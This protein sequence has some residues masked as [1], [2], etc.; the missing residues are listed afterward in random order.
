MRATVPADGGVAT[1]ATDAD[2]GRGAEVGDAGATHRLDGEA[3]VGVVAVVLGADV[4]A[5]GAGVVGIERVVVVV[6]VVVRGVSGA[7]RV[8]GVLVRALVV[9]RAGLG[10]ARGAG[11]E[12]ASSRSD[13]SSSDDVVVDPLDVGRVISPADAHPG[14]RSSVNS[15][16]RRRGDISPPV[17]PCGTRGPTGY[18]TAMRRFVLVAVAGAGCAPGDV[19]WGTGEDVLRTALFAERDPVTE[20]PGVHVFVST[21]LFGCELPDSDDPFEQELLLLELVVGWCREDARH[22]SFDVLHLPDTALEGVYAGEAGA[23]FAS[24]SAERPRLFTAAYIGNEEVIV[25]PSD[26]PQFNAA[27]GGTY[28]PTVQTDLRAV[29]ALGTVRLAGDDGGD[30]LSGRFALPDVHVSGRFRAT[31]CERED[32]MM[33]AIIA[34]SPVSCP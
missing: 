26:L 18:S 19:R 13:S 21:G 34:G 20:G 5:R 29:G 30:A 2:T 17:G 22:L 15:D 1:R 16:R 32:S 7:V 11:R 14:A 8:A 28:R 24:L 9:V 4:G 23:T 25:A 33:Q 10:V 6:V 3:V 27:L 31:R 12:D